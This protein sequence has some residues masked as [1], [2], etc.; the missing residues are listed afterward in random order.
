MTNAKCY[1]SCLS[2]CSEHISREHFISESLLDYLNSNK[3]LTVS[4]LPWLKDTEKVLPP[5]ALAAKILC[6]RHNSALS[7]L[8]EMAVRLFDSFNEEGAVESN[9]KKL[10]IFF[11]NDIER[12]LLKIFCGII[13]SKNMTIADNMNINNHKLWIET[14]FGIRDFYNETGLYIC[15]STGHLFQN[16]EDI[17]LK[18]IARDDE[19]SGIGL[20]LCGYELVLSLKGFPSR[21]FDGREFVYRPMELHTTG[22]KYEKSIILSWDGTA[23]LGSIHCI[24]D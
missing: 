21:Q 9:S 8:D 14:L 2:D 18:M 1:A 7:V 24:I 19:I 3:D 22:K 12:W 11:G 16:L 4:G 23:D 5:N 13:F 10:Y 15:R 20:T 6:Q 17:M